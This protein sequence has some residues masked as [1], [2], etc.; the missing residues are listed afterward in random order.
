MVTGEEVIIG[1]DILESIEQ[2][3]VIALRLTCDSCKKSITQCRCTKRQV[4]KIG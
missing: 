2:D 3:A 1:R 4:R